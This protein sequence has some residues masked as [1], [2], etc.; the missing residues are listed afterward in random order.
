MST[1]FL[2]ALLCITLSTA[3]AAAQT[4]DQF[5]PFITHWEGRKHW[6]THGS[7]GI[8]HNTTRDA[9][10]LYYT[11]PEIEQIYRTDYATAIVA[12][13]SEIRDFDS[14]PD[15]AKLVCLS[16]EWGVGWTGFRE[17]RVFRR[18]ISAHQYKMAA[19][20]LMDSRWASQVSPKRLE[21]HV[22]RLCD[23]EK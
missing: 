20:A 5:E 11:D 7:A 21:D 16:V 23:L 6:A 9:F 18:C 13:R 4:A 19:A 14:L 2:I 10:H 1:R 3:F 8:G 17:F 22:N 15:D 12:V